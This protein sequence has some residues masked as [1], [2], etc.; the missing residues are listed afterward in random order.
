VTEYVGDDLVVSDVNCQCLGLLD[1]SVM[2]LSLHSQSVMLSLAAQ[3]HFCS[4][5]CFLT[6]SSHSQSAVLSPAAQQ[7]FCSSR[8]FLTLFS[9]QFMFVLNSV[10]FC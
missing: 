2:T 1:R 9:H 4:S 8:C 5:R 6:L 10:I 3:Q 7:H